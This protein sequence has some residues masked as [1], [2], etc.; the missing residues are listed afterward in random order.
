MKEYENSYPDNDNDN[1][2]PYPQDNKRNNLNFNNNFEPYYNNNNYNNQPNDNNNNNNNYQRDNMN[3]NL[4]QDNIENQ[5]ININHYQYAQD[6]NKDIN[7]EQD[8]QSIK[9]QQ[10]INYQI[11]KKFLCKVYGIISFQFLLTLI[12]IFIFQIKS[13]KNYF[14]ERPGFT[15]FLSFLCLIGFISTLILLAI[16]QDLAKRVPYNYIS[17]LVI[18]ICISLTCCFLSLSYDSDS[19]I[20]CVVL[21]TISTIIITAYGYYSKS[22]MSTIK[23]LMLVIIGQSGGFFLL[24]FL[25]GGTMIEKVVYFVG[26]LMF[27]IYLVYDT[28]IIMKKF[29]EVFGIDDYIFASIQIYL[30]IANLFMMILSAFGNRNNKV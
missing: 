12:L 25:L 28:Q 18:T 23:T 14:I 17:L 11:F 6:L 29:G 16:K 1:M 19:V 8:N 5:D 13:I 24:M 20:F 22:D 4:I 15:S 9:E 26:T 27:G 7:S 10:E 21:T 2:N 30:D 3:N